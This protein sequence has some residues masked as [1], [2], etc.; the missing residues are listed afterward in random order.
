MQHAHAGRRKA[1]TSGA[2]RHSIGAHERRGRW[3]PLLLVASVVA[4]LTVPL[5][6]SQVAPAPLDGVA[7]NGTAG[8]PYEVADASGLF[9]FAEAANADPAEY[10][11][12]HVDVVADIDF[13]EEQPFPG[14]D[15]FSGT[16]D[17][18]GHTL[19]GLE[20]GPSPS[21]AA[22]LGLIRTLDG[23]TVRNLTIEGLTV[24]NGT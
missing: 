6:A 18:L 11:Y 17:G 15:T 7:G 9:T 19:S 2:E 10:A 5:A 8:D 13:S 4:A 24:D 22:D 21:S 20:Y 1:W 16:L 23:G 3:R 14:L 12:A